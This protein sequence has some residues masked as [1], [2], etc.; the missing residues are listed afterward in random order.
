MPYTCSKQSIVCCGM[1]SVHTN[2]LSSLEV[3]SIL[4]FGSGQVV[5]AVVSVS[6]P[7]AASPVPASPVGAAAP[8]PHAANKKI[9]VTSSAAANLRIFNCLAISLS[10]LQ[11]EVE[12]D[13]GWSIHDSE[14]TA[15][16]PRPPAPPE[17]R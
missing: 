3:T 7:A 10:P 9:A 17:S 4:G 15:R 6:V 11:H 13:L 5:S 12:I 16:L 8:P 2:R 1:Y 14:T